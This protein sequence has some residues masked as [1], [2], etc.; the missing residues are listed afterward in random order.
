MMPAARHIRL[1][2]RDSAPI[3]AGYFPIAV[4]FGLA[5]LQAKV[6]VGMVI[7]ISM[8]VFAGAAQFMLVT[9]A[10]AGASA[11]GIITAVLLMNL[12]H[13]FYGPSLLPRLAL[14]PRHAPM[15]LLAAGLTD[16]VFAAAMGK[17]DKVPAEQREG[18]YMGLE[19]GAYIA[20]VGGTAT[21]ALLG[22]QLGTQAVW[23]QA[24]LDFVLPALFFALLLEIVS[25]SRLRVT[26]SAMLVTLVLL[27]WLP[28]HW[29][30]LG[31]MVAGAVLGA[32]DAAPAGETE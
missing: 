13:L 23:V 2:L 29:A 31:G 11:L 6:S 21:G 7:A 25:H 4:S 10:A 17:V 8:L 14:Q 26:V 24:T 30:M 18:W 28:G 3:M 12:R 20:W 9:L 16:E 27:P 32:L 5:A 19:L 22:H 15:P 1:G